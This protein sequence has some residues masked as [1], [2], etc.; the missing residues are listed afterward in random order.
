MIFYKKSIILGFL[1]LFCSLPLFAQETVYFK[2]IKVVRNNRNISEPSGGQFI[3]FYK[4]ICYESDK[5]GESVG[6]GMLEQVKGTTDEYIRYKGKS[7]W[8]E[9]TFK[10]NKERERLNIIKPDGTIYVYTRAIA[11]AGQTTCSL[12]KRKQETYDSSP[13]YQTTPAWQSGYT[14]EHIKTNKTGIEQ[15]TKPKT[16]VRKKCP[17]CKEGEY[18]QHENV[19][20]FGLDGPRVNC[21]ICKQSWRYGTVHVHHQCPYCKGKGYYEYE[22]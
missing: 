19:T 6:H 21:T 7:Y 22:Y 9:V 15:T 5:Y 20:T 14:N 18:I 4:D 13:S 17:H 8:G 16:V 2:Q 1:I 10:F 12:I 11:P 3:S